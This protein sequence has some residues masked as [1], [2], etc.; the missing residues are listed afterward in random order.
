[1]NTHHHDETTK[2]IHG[3]CIETM[4]Q[5]E[6]ESV[7]AIVTDP[8]YNL[9]NGSKSDAQCF[10]EIVTEVLLP[11]DNN[12]NPQGVESR[13]LAVPPLSGS[14]LGGERRP[15]RVDARVGVPEGPIDLQG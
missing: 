2:V 8:P 7:D 12:R 13:D 9:S 10:R 6:P 3:D 11:H 5:M 14:G 15:V 1:M 4:N